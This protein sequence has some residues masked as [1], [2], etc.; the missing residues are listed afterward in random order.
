M[1]GSALGNGFEGDKNDGIAGGGGKPDGLNKG[2]RPG[3]PM[4]GGGIPPGKG[5]GWENAEKGDE[6]KSIGENPPESAD[7]A[8][9]DERADCGPPNGGGGPANGD[10]GPNDDRSELYGVGLIG[11]RSDAGGSKSQ[12]KSSSEGLAH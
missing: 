8:S 7:C 4:P 1:Y 12:G 3:G 5:G 9:I 11:Q 6:E 10:G 2:E